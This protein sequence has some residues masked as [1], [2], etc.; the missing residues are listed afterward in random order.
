MSD[1]I[2]DGSF[3][4]LKWFPEGNKAHELRPPDHTA[5]VPRKPLTVKNF[6]DD[7]IEKRKP[8]FVRGG[9]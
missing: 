1:E 3:D 5:L 7:W 8:P 9:F 4:Y 6:Y 2:K